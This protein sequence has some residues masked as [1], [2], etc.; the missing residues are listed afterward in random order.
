MQRTPQW[1]EGPAWFEGLPWGVTHWSRQPPRSQCWEPPR[2]TPPGVLGRQR[3]AK[4]VLPADGRR[5]SWELSSSPPPPRPVNLY[6]FL[7]LAV[8]S[9]KLRLI[10][11]PPAQTQTC[12]LFENSLL[13]YINQGGER[14]KNSSNRNVPSA[15]G[16]PCHQVPATPPPSTGAPGR[17]AG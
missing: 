8:S 1:L 10:T 12:L 6:Y 7:L 17:S 14:K 2:L 15:R 13:H 4:S 11:R 3:E 9:N 16:P 5:A